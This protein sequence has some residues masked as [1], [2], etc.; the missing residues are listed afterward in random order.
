MT[1]KLSSEDVFSLELDEFVKNTNK[2]LMEFS[3][4]AE[5]FNFGLDFQLN[6]TSMGSLLKVAKEYQPYD[7]RDVTDFYGEEVDE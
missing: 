3:R 2:K 7:D 6:F 1:D 4:R 5:D